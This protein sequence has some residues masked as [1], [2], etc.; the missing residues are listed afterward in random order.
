VNAQ[1][2]T[3]CIDLMHQLRYSTVPDQTIASLCTDEDCTCFF[4]S[5]LDDLLVAINRGNEDKDICKSLDICTDEQEKANM[6]KLKCGVCAAALDKVWDRVSI[7]ATPNQVIDILNETCSKYPS[8]QDIC[9]S[10]QLKGTV[11]RIIDG[12]KSNITPR[13]TCSNLNFCSPIQSSSSSAPVLQPQ[14]TPNVKQNEPTKLRCSICKGVFLLA[15][16]QIK[17]TNDIS[18]VQQ[19]LSAIC[20]T[21]PPAIQASCIELSQY[22]G[23]FE[24]SIMSDSDAAT[25][26]KAVNFCS[27]QTDSIF[28]NSKSLTSLGA[29]PPM[30]CQACQWA[31]SAIEAYLSQD[32]NVQELA[33]VLE[34][35]CTVLP[36]P[37]VPICKNF[38]TLYLD[39][40][41][42]VLLD[43]LTPPYVCA[44]L[45]AC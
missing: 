6:I 20:K 34:A 25:T 43:N 41:L 29:I 3:V 16:N 33:G 28:S 44:K 38:V 12:I 17:T 15:K 7:D 2:C 1:N 10:L 40:A 18:K 26:C 23:L 11:L 14:T 21:V 42:L 13:E 22:E 36:D 8:S 32:P 30:E 19:Q 39:E 9:R 24:L 31:V 4:L 37:Y 35:L 27:S 5:R 45:S